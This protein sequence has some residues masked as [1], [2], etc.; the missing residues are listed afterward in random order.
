MAL[1][2]PDGLRPVAP[3]SWTERSGAPGVYQQTVTV[4]P[5]S[6][7]PLPLT[8]DVTRTPAFDQ[9][10]T[11]SISVD[12]N[13][14]GT[15][16]TRLIRLVSAPAAVSASSSVAPTSYVGEQPGVVTVHVSNTGGTT[17]TGVTVS[18]TLPVGLAVRDGSGW[19]QRAATTVYDRAV[20]VGP[21]GTA[22][23]TLPVTSTRVAGEVSGDV[24]VDVTYGVATPI[25]AQHGVT[26]SPAPATPSLTITGSV[27]TEFVAGHDGEVWFTITNTGNTTL[28]NL[29]AQV[30]KNRPMTWVDEDRTDEWLCSS[31]GAP[32]GV[33]AVCELGGVVSRESH[34]LEP[35]DVTVLKLVMNSPTH[36]ENGHALPVTIRVSADGVAAVDGTINVPVAEHH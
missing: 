15:P 16:V 19:T 4:D 28:R 2:L 34:D 20:T 31:Y 1:G 9:D 13:G 18:V 10:E 24:V 21:A 22:T 33:D 35:G 27:E 12:L 11:Q 32:S 8:L 29:Q 36:T 6:S 26:V 25:T 3:G 30:L 14:A 17:A 7:L 5:E 23:V